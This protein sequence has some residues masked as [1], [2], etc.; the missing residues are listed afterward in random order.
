MKKTLGKFKEVSLREIFPHEAHDFTQWL[1]KEENIQEINKIIGL[2][3]VDIK[4]EVSIGNKR[5]DI[6]AKDEFTNKK[7]IIENQLEKT[8]HDHLGK[9]ITYASGLNASVIIWIVKKA[10]LE[11]S[12]AIEWLNNNISEDISFF[13][14]E[15]KLYQIND[16]LPAIQFEIIEKP[17]DFI[18]SS[19]SEK[20]NDKLRD[21][22]KGRIA[23]WSL[24]NEVMEERKEFNIR[25]ASKDH[26]YDFAIGTTRCHLSVELLNQKNKVR[27]NLLIR[28]DKQL[29]DSLNDNKKQIEID[30]PFNLEWYK[31]ENIKTTRVSTYLDG[32]SFDSQEDEQKKLSNKIIDILVQFRKH[33]KKYIIN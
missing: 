19:S 23:F 22:E 20:N 11:F 12:G 31:S 9:I 27:I 26:W 7:V 8:N 1:S 17:N 13:L 33:F 24:F 21:S 2:S 28:D 29:Y 15:V 5:C 4:T 16:S 30:L 10:N 6:V 18:K 3:L 32:F 14:L 25:K